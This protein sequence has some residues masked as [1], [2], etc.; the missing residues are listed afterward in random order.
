M[1]RLTNPPPMRQ[2]LVPDFLLVYI[3]TSF[4]S[5]SSWSMARARSLREVFQSDA[6][7]TRAA[8]WIGP[9]LFL[10]GVESFCPI[11]H[12]LAF[13]SPIP[14]GEI[15]FLFVAFPSSALT[16]VRPDPATASCA[17]WLPS[18][19]TISVPLGM[20]QF[21]GSSRSIG[22]APS[23]PHAPQS[24]SYCPLTAFSHFKKFGVAVL[25]PID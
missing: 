17:S 16:I 25:L 19:P 6:V 14:R 21:P 12:L 18:S 4:R 11:R 15:L 10:T 8:R 5:F 9:L 2:R 7:F 22:F 20:M 1:L 13:S 24:K 23:P 3:A